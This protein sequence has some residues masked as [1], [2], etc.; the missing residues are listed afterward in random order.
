MKELR[1]TE[2]ERERNNSD[3]QY[4]AL[5]HCISE[6]VENVKRLENRIDELENRSSE[7]VF[8]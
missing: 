1:W 7:I 5:G 8:K 3:I 6:L 2:Y 4:L